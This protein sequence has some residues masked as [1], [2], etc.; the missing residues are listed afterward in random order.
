M[1]K[2]LLSCL[3]A[4]SLLS[5]SVFGAKNDKIRGMIIDSR[6]NVPLSDGNFR[7]APMIDTTTNITSEFI[8]LDNP[9]RSHSF[10]SG[11][12]GEGNVISC[13]VHLSAGSISHFSRNLSRKIAEGREMTE[14][15]ELSLGDICANCKNFTVDASIIVIFP[16]DG[17]PGAFYSIRDTFYSGLNFVSSRCIPGGTLVDRTFITNLN[18]IPNWF[19][20]KLLSVYSSPRDRLVSTESTVLLT[21]PSPTLLN[22]H[23][24]DV[25]HFE[26]SYHQNPANHFLTTNLIYGILSKYYFPMQHQML[27]DWLKRDIRVLNSAISL[28][29]A[30]IHHF[31]MG[32]LSINGSNGCVPV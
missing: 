11:L 15:P 14:V 12:N 5:I 31:D 16:T 23:G 8:N 29:V 26:F 21:L 30:S 9:V 24:N 6:F 1:Y 20:I 10:M 17:V 7:V 22:A 18:S 4:F 13:N 27:I 3:L 28:M 32:C 19:Q 2:Q 25:I